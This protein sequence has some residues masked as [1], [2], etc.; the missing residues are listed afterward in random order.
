M[1]RD[2]LVHFAGSSGKTITIA[3]LR[4]PLAPHRAAYL[5]DSI[6]QLDSHRHAIAGPELDSG[7]GYVN[8]VCRNRLDH[9]AVGQRFEPQG[10][11]AE[12]AF[13]LEGAAAVD[14]RR[15][16]EAALQRDCAD[17][18]LLAAAAACCPRDH[19]AADAAAGS[20]R[21]LAGR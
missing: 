17:A 14:D 16:R 6:G 5:R 8:A 13:E 11:D 18:S 2:V 7:I 12:Q 19:R 21:D 1:N 3:P 15:W 10:V 9:E 4:D 20:R